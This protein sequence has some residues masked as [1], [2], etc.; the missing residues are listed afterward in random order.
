[1]RKPYII[2]YAEEYNIQE[3]I[4]L[5]YDHNSQVNYLDKDKTRLAACFELQDRTIET[6]VIENSDYDES[7]LGPNTTRQTATLEDTDPDE[8]PFI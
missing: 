4:T 3:N 5:F 6:R 2:Q 7:Y 8:Y 1:M